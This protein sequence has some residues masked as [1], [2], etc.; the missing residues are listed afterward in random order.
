[1]KLGNAIAAGLFLYTL[2]TCR[3]RRYTASWWQ[4]TNGGEWEFRVQHFDSRPELLRLDWFD[5]GKS[6]RYTVAHYM[7]EKRRAA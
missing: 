5:A 6:K 7:V 4:Q 1:M 2:L 3:R